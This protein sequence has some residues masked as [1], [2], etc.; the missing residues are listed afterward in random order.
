MKRAHLHS[1]P[2]ILL[3]MDLSV[4]YSSKSLKRDP[5]WIVKIHQLK[6]FLNP[7]YLRSFAHLKCFFSDASAERNGC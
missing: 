2:I 7:F 3:Q 6:S 4:I 5:T 1:V